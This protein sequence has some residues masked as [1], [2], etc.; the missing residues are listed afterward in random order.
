MVTLI[1]S[2]SFSVLALYSMFRFTVT[3]SGLAGSLKLSSF[4]VIVISNTYAFPPMT[5]QNCSCEKEPISHDRLVILR[6]NFG[7][8]LLLCT[9]ANCKVMLI[10]PVLSWQ[11]VCCKI[12][13]LGIEFRFNFGF[14]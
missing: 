2:F 8:V 12:K 3:L 7:E 11:N 6:S 13:V 5:G 9:L 4:I 14:S 1:S 10:P